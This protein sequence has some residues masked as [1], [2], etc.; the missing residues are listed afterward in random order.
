MTHAKVHRI[1]PFCEATC[2]LELS[3]RGRTVERVRGDRQDPFSAGYIC[4]KGVALKDLVGDPDV[5]TEPLIRSEAG[6]RKVT[7]DEAF[8][9]IERGLTPVLEQHGRDAVGVYA[10][11]P[12]VHNTA[13]TLYLP[14]LLRALRTRNFFSAG[15]ADQIPKQLVA[16]LLFGTGL[17]VP[18]PDLD[19]CQFLLIL[20]ANPLVSNGSLMTA[21]NVAGRLRRLRQRG[22]KIVVVDPRRTKTAAAADEHLFIK[23]GTDAFFL[24]GIVHTLFD[25]QLAAP[26]P[27]AGHALGMERIAELAR[28]FPPEEVSARCGIPAADIRRVARQIAAARAAAVYGRIGT[29][30]QQFGTLAS[31]LPEVIHVVTGNLD[32]AGGAMFTKAA[33]GPSNTKGTPGSGRG[34]RLG[35]VRSRV[36]GRGEVLGELPSSCLAEEIDTPGDGRVRALITVSGNPVL[37]TANGKRLARAL[38]TLDFMVSLDIYRN[39]TTRH[40]NVI[41]PGLSP[42]ERCHYDIALSQFAVHNY[43]RYSAPL[44]EPSTETQTEWESLLRLAGIA[45]GLG[46]RADLAALDERVIGQLIERETSQPTSPVHGRDPAELAAALAPR[47]GPPRILDF[48]LRTGPYGDRFGGDPQ[49]NAVNDFSARNSRSSGRSR[50]RENSE[51]TVNGPNSHEFGYQDSSRRCPQGLTLA[52]LE[53]TPRGIDLGPLQPRIP[54]VLRTGSGKIEL[55]PEPIVADVERLKEALQESPA[56]GSDSLQLIGRRHLFTN[57]SWMHNLERLTIGAARCTLQIHP[58]DARA[59][60]L[61]DRQRAV[62]TSRVGTLQVPVEIDPDIMPG[63]VSL[64]HG[65]GHGDRLVGLRV[66]ARSA[67]VCSND[68]TDE[69]VLDVPSGNAVLCGIPVTVRT[70]DDL[71]G[72]HPPVVARESGQRLCPGK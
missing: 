57:N 51:G 49:G 22:G 27:L 11:N 41:L 60:G 2:G 20:G 33:H 29:C 12:V 13:L 8:A 63:V 40:A 6:W 18:I 25:E 28:A 38:E 67:G 26:G 14:V 59:R 72:L 46:S 10:G 37:S 44:F 31:W 64:P 3:V 69:E 5:L 71:D 58:A 17:S 55:A 48:L 4:P 30:T 35:R 56:A 1:C 39:E 61:V 66:A 45:S 16:A 9:E 70:A 23:P 34:V 36:R 15:T 24:F 21:P 53:E 43:A 62:V 65:W 42:L 19:R 52:L 47:R 54:E 50:I 7:W 68:L 32:R